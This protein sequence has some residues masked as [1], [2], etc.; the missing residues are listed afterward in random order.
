MHIFYPII[1]TEVKSRQN[2]GRGGRPMDALECIRTRMSIRK[3][4]P[5]PVPAE[6]L[7]KVIETARW[8]PSYKNSQPWEVVVVSGAKKD[9]LTKLLSG[10]LEQ[11]AAPCP[12]FPEPKSWPAEIDARIAALMKKRGEL[13]GMDLNS[14]EV[15]RR[16]RLANFSFYGAPH[17]LFI[18]QDGSLTEWS[19]LDLGMFCQSIMLAAHACG[20][21]TVPQ[22]FLTDYARH[23][24]EFLGIPASKRLALGM[25]IGHP[26]M[27]S[28]A[29][30]FRTERV[31][32]GLIVR[33]VE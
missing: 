2:A 32:T 7:M 24:K 26:D 4:R 22:A 13:S 20:L 33:M 11:G 28:K 12:D 23:T 18:L 15:R 30:A 31:D 27:A 9:E 8:S 25:S 16:S 14:P 10:L 3:F 21:G 6:T 1:N 17:G 5:E 19:V 29:N